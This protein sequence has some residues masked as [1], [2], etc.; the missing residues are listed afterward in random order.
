MKR[1]TVTPTLENRRSRLRDTDP[2]DCGLA[3]SK[4]DEH[5][6]RAGSVEA[7]RR[8]HRLRDGLEQRELLYRL[9]VEFVTLAQEQADLP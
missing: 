9:T 2:L 8:G 4:V 1:T 7:A 6:D 5:S 3:V